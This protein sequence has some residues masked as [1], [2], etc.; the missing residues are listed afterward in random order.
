MVTGHHVGYNSFGGLSNPKRSLAFLNS[1]QLKLLSLK[2]F[3]NQICLELNVLID[4]TFKGIIKLKCE[5]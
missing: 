5:H 1:S 4:R 2:E 3:N